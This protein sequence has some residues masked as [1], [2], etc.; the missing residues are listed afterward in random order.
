[1]TVG[2]ECDDH[3][4]VTTVLQYFETLTGLN[5]PQT[6]DRIF[7]GACK[8]TPVWLKGYR[9]HP[10]RIP[11]YGLEAVTRGNIPHTNGLIISTTGEHIPIRSESNRSYSLI[12]TL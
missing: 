11:L 4:S 12:V 10:V 5:T 1:M 8:N 2:A 7:T 6:N 3:R 9:P